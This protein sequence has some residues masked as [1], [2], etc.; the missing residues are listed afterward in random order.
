MLQIA[1]CLVWQHVTQKA[2]G[3][4]KSEIASASLE[5]RAL[6]IQED[7]GGSGVRKRNEEE[8]Q[9]RELDRRD[10]NSSVEGEKKN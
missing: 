3:E 2:T 5:T 1:R 6:T 8:S 9:G 7:G 4:L 10:E